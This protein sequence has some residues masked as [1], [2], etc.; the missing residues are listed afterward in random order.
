MASEKTM[1]FCIFQSRTQEYS[2]IKNSIIKN[3]TVFFAGRISNATEIRLKL[4]TLA[5]IIRQKRM[6]FDI[7]LFSGCFFFCPAVYT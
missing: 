6:S 3:T 4:N 7:M 2:I 5:E 1:L